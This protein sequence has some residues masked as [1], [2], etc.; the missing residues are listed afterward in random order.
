MCFDWYVDYNLNMLKHQ[1]NN[2]CPSIHLTSKT[3][4]SR[5]STPTKCCVRS[6]ALSNYISKPIR[7]PLIFNYRNMDV[8]GKVH[9]WLRLRLPLL[10]PTLCACF[11]LY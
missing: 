6:L 8:L 7:T 11:S 4:N 5:S 2:V 10:A 1:F 9:K 3:T